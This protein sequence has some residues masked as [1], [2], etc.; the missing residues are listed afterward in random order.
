[1]IHNF[2]RKIITIIC[3]FWQKIITWCEF[4][5]YKNDSWL[6][7]DINWLVARDML[8]HTMWRVWI[9][10]DLKKQLEVME[11]EPDIKER[12]DLV[13]FPGSVAVEDSS[14]LQTIYP[15][16]MLIILY[17]TNP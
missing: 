4:K 1:M 6:D 9:E 7:H 15:G 2:W 13:D 10:G 12:L 14:Q 3:I 5:D 11:I 8:I 16:K 17:K